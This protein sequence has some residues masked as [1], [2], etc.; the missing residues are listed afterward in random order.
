MPDVETAPP[1]ELSPPVVET[2]APPVV[3]EP[4]AGKTFTQDEL[5]AIIKRERAAAERAAQALASSPPSAPDS[6][7]R[8]ASRACSRSSLTIE[9]SLRAPLLRCDAPISSRFR[10]ALSKCRVPVAPLPPPAHA[11]IQRF[12]Y[13]ATVFGLSITRLSRALLRA[14]CVVTVVIVVAAELCAAVATMPHRRLA[15]E[16][17][18]REQRDGLFHDGH[19]DVPMMGGAA[20]PAKVAAP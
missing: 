9:R 6:G 1:T 10:G 13:F 15:L 11:F 20:T 19:V 3:E 2:P 16:F 12:V 14:A 4:P 17:G 8:L 5:G 7:T 18:C